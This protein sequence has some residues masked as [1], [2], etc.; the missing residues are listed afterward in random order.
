LLKRPRENLK[1]ARTLRN[2]SRP[3]L[4]AQLLR[5][6][7]QLGTSQE[8]RLDSNLIEKWE[9]GESHPRPFY[10]ARLCLLYQATP[11]ELDLRPSALLDAEISRF[12]GPKKEGQSMSIS[13]ASAVGLNPPS[14]QAILPSGEHRGVET[15]SSA[16]ERVLFSATAVPTPGESTFE[17]LASRVLGA[18]GHRKN[19]RREKPVLVVVSGFPGSGKTEFGRF[20]STITGWVLLDKDTLT[21]SLT[22]SLLLALGSE[23]DDRHSTLY[24]EQVRPWEY[25]CLLDTAF[26]NLTCGISTIIVA[27]FLAEITNEAWLKRLANRCSAKSVEMKMVWMACD[28]DTMHERLRKRGATRDR[29]KVSR[30]N[31]YLASID[32]ALRPSCA[33]SIVDNHFNS[34]IS[35]AEQ[36]QELANRV[37]V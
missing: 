31:E 23:T 30:W 25:I 26:D 37:G 35:L 17:D 16:I 13:S 36:A 15:I 2:W 28:V 27:P 9:I 3:E 22:D 1:K 29:W 24:N 19:S 12:R 8:I 5:Q 11:T 10:A 7:E 32:I 6:E 33:H 34:T 14:N 21:R 18:W 4:V 20:L